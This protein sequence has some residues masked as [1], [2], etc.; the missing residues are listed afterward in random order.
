[1]IYF[2]NIIYLLETKKDFLLMK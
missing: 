2:E 1:L